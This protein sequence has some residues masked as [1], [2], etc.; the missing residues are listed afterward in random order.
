MAN[1]LRRKVHPLAAGKEAFTGSIYKVC[2]DG[3]EGDI[4]SASFDWQN[5]GTKQLDPSS[6]VNGLKF[7]LGGSDEPNCVEADFTYISGSAGL[8]IYYK[9]NG[10]GDWKANIS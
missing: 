2:A 4:L 8:R 5:Q 3:D 1:P 9:S 10:S 7:E 6:G